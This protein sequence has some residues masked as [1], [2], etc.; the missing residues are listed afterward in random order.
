MSVAKKRRM[1]S[2]QPRIETPANARI[3]VRTQSRSY[4]GVHAVAHAGPSS[5]RRRRLLSPS[6][7]PADLLGELVPALAVADARPEA[8]RAR[9]RLGLDSPEQHVQALQH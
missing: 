7:A 2:P 6:G 1:G 3:Q 5:A 8:P 4:G 9:L